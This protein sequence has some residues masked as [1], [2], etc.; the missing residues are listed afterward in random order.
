LITNALKHAFSESESGSIK[1]TLKHKKRGAIDLSIADR[2]R[3]LPE[4]F[5]MEGKSTSL[6]MKIVV[7]T[8]RQLGGTLEINRLKP[9]TE[10]LIHL[11]ADI[12]RA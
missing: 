7:S 11:P 12:A 8:V 6:G 3:G 10:F 4:D 1:V 5:K 9:G 2:G